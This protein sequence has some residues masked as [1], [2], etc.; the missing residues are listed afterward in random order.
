[1]YVDKRYVSSMEAAWRLLNFEVEKKFPSILPLPIHLENQ[2]QVLINCDAEWCKEALENKV[3]NSESTPLTEYFKNNAQEIK[4]PLTKAQLGQH[5]D[6]TIKAKGPDILYGNYPKYYAWDHKKKQWKR[7][8]NKTFQIGRLHTVHKGANERFY[9][10]LLLN[11]VSG[12]TSYKD[13]MKVDDMV[14]NNFK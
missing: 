11:H 13:L 6:G 2:N 5:E 3:K 1:D 10:R 9:L 7:R 14:F 12:S 4:Q 8:K